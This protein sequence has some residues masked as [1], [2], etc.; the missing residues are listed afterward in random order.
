MLVK[1]SSAQIVGRRKCAQSLVTEC[2]GSRRVAA[3]RFPFPAD[4]E[5]RIKLEAVANVA[6]VVSDTAPMT[7]AP[8]DGGQC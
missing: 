6:D 5:E 1:A 4:H 2:V 3:G 7:Q 8:S